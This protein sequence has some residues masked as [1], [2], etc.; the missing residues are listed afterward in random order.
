LPAYPSSCFFLDSIAVARRG[1]RAT[2]VQNHISRQL[3]PTTRPKRARLPCRRHPPQSK[4]PIPLPVAPRQ[5][6]RLI[7]Y[8]LTTHPG[9]PPAIPAVMIVSAC[10]HSLPEEL[11][12]IN[13]SPMFVPLCSAIRHDTRPRQNIQ[14]SEPILIR[15]IM[16][17]GVIV[18]MLAHILGEK[19][20]Q[21]HL[22]K[23]CQIPRTFHQRPRQHR[24]KQLPLP[25]HPRHSHQR[26]QRIDN[27]RR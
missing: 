25:N 20:R 24:L 18:L 17:M 27:L 22:P 6:T 7:Q 14:T 1:M 23:H 10:L 8:S 9:H 3:N 4:P 26:L 16:V 5:L 21:K 13:P 19:V 2:T 11:P 12:Q 15:M